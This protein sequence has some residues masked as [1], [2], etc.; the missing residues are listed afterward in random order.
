MGAIINASIDLTKIDESKVVVG[1]NGNRYYNISLSINDNT[2]QYGNNVQ[3][4]N[5]QTKEQREAKEPR[6][7]LGNGKVAFVSGNITVASKNE[8]PKF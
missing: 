3:V 2:D 1:K 5:P 8:Q 7:F 6:V 4:T